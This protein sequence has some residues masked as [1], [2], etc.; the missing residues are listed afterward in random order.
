MELKFWYVVDGHH[1]FQARQFSLK[2]SLWLVSYEVFLILA[3]I[4]AVRVVPKTSS[5]QFFQKNQKLYLIFYIF[6]NI[7]SFD[8]F[9]FDK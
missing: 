3:T 6:V 8:S 1:I 4:R 7:G 5:Y 9:Q 2:T